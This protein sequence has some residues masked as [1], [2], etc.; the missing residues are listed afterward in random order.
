MN[1]LTPIEEYNNMLFKREDLFQRNFKGF[2][3]NGSKLRSI[4]DTLIIKKELIASKYS[5]CI[6]IKAE[7]GSHTL[8]NILY[9][10]NQLGITIINTK[11]IHSPIWI[12]LIKD[13][14][15]KEENC[16]YD[17]APYFAMN[18]R[19]TV[20]NHF[21]YTAN[22]EQVS[23]IPRG[24]DN[25]IISYGSSQTLI[26]LLKGIKQYGNIPKRIIAI[27]NK[28]PNPLVFYEGFP[29]DHIIRCWK[30][31]DLPKITPP[32][33]LDSRFELNAW[34][35]LQKYET[36]PEIKNKKN[37]FWITGNYNF[38]REVPFI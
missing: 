24:L 36:Y 38:L 19:Y 2:K 15:Y 5:N 28:E 23:N 12:D 16:C 8:I 20:P 26:A 33:D 1:K 4:L 37:L 10:C 30:D 22:I 32:I 14:L 34:R 21:S 35:Y 18:Q 27:G 17:L 31:Y 13:S 3:L 9:A 29:C 11:K 7:E 6:K 25:I